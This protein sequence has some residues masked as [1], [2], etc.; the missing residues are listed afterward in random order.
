MFE[1]NDW[2]DVENNTEANLPNFG[3]LKNSKKSRSRKRK[4]KLKDKPLQSTTLLPNVNEKVKEITNKLV[5]S[6]SKDKFLNSPS[7]TKSLINNS[8]HEEN[9]KNE[10]PITKKRSTLSSMSGESKKINGGNILNKGIK[11][12]SES[13]FLKFITQQ[14]KKRKRSKKNKNSENTKKQ[15]IEEQK[16]IKNDTEPSTN[17]ELVPQKTSNAV[18]NQLNCDFSTPKNK[19]NGVVPHTGFN[20]GKLSEIL[21]KADKQ[22]S[23]NEH[24]EAKR[25]LKSSRFRFL[26]EKLYTQSGSQS[27]KMFKNDR[28][29]MDTFKTYHE[30]Y[31]EQVKKWPMDPLDLIIR[32]VNSRCGIKSY[33]FGQMLTPGSIPL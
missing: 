8:E 21:N 9:V 15:K 17:A 14:P 7:L 32:Y 19:G 6:K 33:I 1:T 3:E 16:S 12:T 20:V 22:Q 27:F 29:G 28:D 18:K 13:Q 25:K 26:N 24:S 5:T 23:C 11:F 30:G 2:S 4:N 31:A 10:I